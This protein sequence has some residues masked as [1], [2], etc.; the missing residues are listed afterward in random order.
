VR[1]RLP[2]WQQRLDQ[3]AQARTEQ[4][5]RLATQLA[6]LRM[7]PTPADPP[8]GVGGGW[9]AEVDPAPLTTAEVTITWNGQMED[10]FPIEAPFR[11]PPCDCATCRARRGEE[12]SK[13]KRAD[14]LLR[15]FLTEEQA[16]T[17]E[18][19]WFDVVAAS[20]KRFR[21]TP[22]GV[23]EMGD[24]GRVLCSYC[25]QMYGYPKGDVVLGRKL[26]LETNE[27]EFL[28]IAVRGG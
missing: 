14:E 16:G 20:G 5:Q 12:E 10:D 28:R 24:S 25:I 11:Q 7:E 9:V 19:G 13:N 4:L 22:S 3:A 6:G 1:F 21:L 2:D 17:W 8:P 18:R 26:L 15:G 27:D 23:F